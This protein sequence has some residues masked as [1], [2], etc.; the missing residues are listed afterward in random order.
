MYRGLRGGEP[1]SPTRRS[2][3]TNANIT[4]TLLGTYQGVRRDVARRF[5]DD[6]ATA[7]TSC[8]TASSLE[9]GHDR[10]RSAESFHGSYSITVPALSL[11]TFTIN[12]VSA[13]DTTHAYVTQPGYILTPGVDFR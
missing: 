8:R 4:G 1:P 7:T 9:P 3:L 5:R 10:R 6:R 2:V 11:N 13:P 12:L